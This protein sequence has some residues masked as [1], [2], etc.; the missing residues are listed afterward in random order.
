VEK[1]TI[2]DMSDH[3][4]KAVMDE[5]DTE[6]ETLWSVADKKN[7]LL[8]VG[9]LLVLMADQECKQLGLGEGRVN[10]FLDRKCFKEGER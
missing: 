5:L 4:L 6:I 7:A 10:L 9:F 3:D 2:E 8:S 1:K